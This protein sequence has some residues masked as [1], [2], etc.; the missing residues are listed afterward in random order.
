M[1]L[2]P[3]RRDRRKITVL[4]GWRVFSYL[5]ILGWEERVLA[6]LVISLWRPPTYTILVYVTWNYRADR[7][8]LWRQPCN[9]LGRDN[10]RIL[11]NTAKTPKSKEP[12]CFIIGCKPGEC[13]ADWNKIIQ[14]SGKLISSSTLEPLDISGSKVYACTGLIKGSKDTFLVMV[15]NL[16]NL[17]RSFKSGLPDI[18]LGGFFLAWWLQKLN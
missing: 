8:S 10:V 3:S 18:V 14:T 4:T 16:D 12:D 13:G 5:L 2:R 11:K 17:P 1:S 6:P 9:G 15:W 7:R